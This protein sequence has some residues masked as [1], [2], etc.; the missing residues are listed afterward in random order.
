M[1]KLLASMLPACCLFAVTAAAQLR[2][3][4]KKICLLRARPR[5]RRSARRQTG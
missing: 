2:P 1:Y 4:C 3:S 5:G